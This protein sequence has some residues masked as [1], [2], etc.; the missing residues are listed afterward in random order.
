M[1]RTKFI[2]LIAMAV[3]IFGAMS[4]FTIHSVTGGQTANLAQVQTCDQQDEDSAAVANATDA[5][6]VDLQCGDQTADESAGQAANEKGEQPE[7]ANTS[8]DETAESAA[9]QG[10]ASISAAQ[11][12]AAVLAQNPGVTVQKTSLDQENGNVVYSVELSNGQDVKVD[13]ASGQILGL[14]SAQD[15]EG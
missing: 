6:Q 11:A 14:D 15:F 2:A 1:K 8:E 5:D 9:L 4:A 10:Q 3:L 12:E 7:G 13:A